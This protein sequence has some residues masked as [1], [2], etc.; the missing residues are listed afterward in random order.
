M[1]N[2][3]TTIFIIFFIFIF[4][5]FNLPS[6]EQ[7]TNFTTIVKVDKKAAAAVPQIDQK[8]AM[9]VEK[10]GGGI[11]ND[12]FEALIPL[13]P[14]LVR[15]E[16]TNHKNEIAERI[17]PIYSG[18]IQES[19]SWENSATTVDELLTDAQLVAPYFQS[20][21]LEIAKN[22]HS[23]AN[24][25]IN[26]R[27][28][29]KSK[30]SLSRKVK[31]IIKERN[32]S[33]KEAVAK[34]RDAVRG[35]IVARSPEQIPF[36]VKSIRNFAHEMK[37]DVVFTNAWEENLASGYVGVHAKMLLPVFE[38]GESYSNRSIAVEL[39]I[40]LQCIMDGTMGSVKEREH[41]LYEK[42]REGK[43]D[44]QLQSAASTLLY[45]TALKQCPCVSPSK[46]V[47][48]YPVCLRSHEQCPVQGP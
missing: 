25:G 33:E 11:Y 5:Q 12:N 17:G 15:E 44:P 2:Q 3:K 18:P 46:Q 35:T 20:K 38:K 16:W 30:N 48:T 13:F 40:H 32:I 23:I 34:V 6:F 9:L 8:A 27:Y 39:Q 29:I 22:T 41:L 42:M 43:T 47:L 45:L 37:C 21:S 26:D 36:I 24:F 7:K 28:V 1:N 31:Q 14:S 4:S 10:L 19:Q